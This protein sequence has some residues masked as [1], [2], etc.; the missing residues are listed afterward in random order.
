MEININPL[1]PGILPG[2]LLGILIGIFVI[3]LYVHNENSH[4]IHLMEQEQNRI[5]KDIS[6]IK[7]ILSDPQ[8]TTFE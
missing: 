5:T 6:S 1:K 3:T 7:E 2:I 4:R 8:K